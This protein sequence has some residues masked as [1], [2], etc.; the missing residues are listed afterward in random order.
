MTA[1]TTEEMRAM[2]TLH[3]DLVGAGADPQYAGGLVRR[4]AERAKARRDAGMGKF[5][6]HRFERPPG[7]P[8]PVISGEQ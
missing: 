5:N 1:W 4:A 8:R 6:L 7:I 3:R 2:L